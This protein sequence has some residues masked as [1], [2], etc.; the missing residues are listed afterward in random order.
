MLTLNNGQLATLAATTRFFTSIWTPGFPVKKGDFGDTPIAFAICEIE[1]SGAQILIDLDEPYKARC[2]T[3]KMEN[4]SSRI[5]SHGF[6]SFCMESAVT[7][8]VYHQ[9]C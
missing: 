1:K 6:L 7:T 4:Y 3:K 8:K 2:R 9:F 5:L